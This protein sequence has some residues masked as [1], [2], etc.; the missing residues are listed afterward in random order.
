MEDNLSDYL[1][2]KDIDPTYLD[3]LQRLY[4]EAQSTL[5]KSRNFAEKILGKKIYIYTTGDIEIK[6]EK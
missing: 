3:S 5:Y 4:K 1:N 6:E 2:T